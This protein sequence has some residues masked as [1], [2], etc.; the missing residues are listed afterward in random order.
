VWGH[1]GDAAKVQAEDE[2]CRWGQHLLAVTSFIN[3][4]LIVLSV[5]K[6]INKFFSP[7]GRASANSAEQL[8]ILILQT[9][10]YTIIAFAQ[11]VAMVTRCLCLGVV[12]LS[13]CR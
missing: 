13:C 8:A 7:T 9:A 2:N 12:G 11:F 4:L 6:D 1:A 10:L 3:F 5:V